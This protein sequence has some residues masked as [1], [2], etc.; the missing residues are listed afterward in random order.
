MKDLPESR[1]AFVNVL[2]LYRAFCIAVSTVSK[3]ASVTSREISTSEVVIS[4][5]SAFVPAMAEK[6]FAAMPGVFFIAGSYTE[7]LWLTE[8]T[9][10]FTSVSF[11]SLVV[12]ASTSTRS[13]SE[14]VKD[15]PVKAPWVGAMDI[16]SMLIL[17]SAMDS[18]IVAIE[19]T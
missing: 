19:S 15:R 8:L 10:T 4:R 9:I 1:E 3:S 18:N 13:L 2:K 11:F 7:I 16:M 14:I 6:T 12:K 5:R 17:Y